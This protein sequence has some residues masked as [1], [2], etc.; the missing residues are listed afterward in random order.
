MGNGRSPIRT[1]FGSAQ[2]LSPQP[3]ACQHTLSRQD[4]EHLLVSSV[5]YGVLKAFLFPP[6]LQRPSN[7]YLSVVA[8]RPVTNGIS[9][10]QTWDVASLKGDISTPH[11]CRP[12]TVLPPCRAWVQIYTPP[13]YT[14]EK[15]KKRRLQS[16]WHNKAAHQYQKK[17]SDWKSR[18]WD[19]RHTKHTQGVFSNDLVE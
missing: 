16:T 5:K 6:L 2:Q 3:Y 11:H 12:A 18:S 13:C 19:V 17:E 14:E 4:V 1:L 10:W 8:Q 7:I 15:K 9:M